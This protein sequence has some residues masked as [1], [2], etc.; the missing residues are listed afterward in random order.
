MGIFALG[1]GHAR[2]ARP[3][4]RRATRFPI[5]TGEVPELVRGFRPAR[6]TRR[7]TL[8]IRIWRG[9]TGT[10]RIATTPR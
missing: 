8:S 9:I 1:A 6:T 10:R 4:L 7:R 3:A 2:R 5:L